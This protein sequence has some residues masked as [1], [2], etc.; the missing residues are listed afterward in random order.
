MHSPASRAGAAQ[1]LRGSAPA[2]DVTCVSMKSC[3]P[4]KSDAA[5]ERYLAHAALRAKSWPVPSEERVV[6][7]SFGQT[8]VRVSGPPDAA[9]V[10]LLPGIG[11]PGLTLAP[12]VAGLS[13]PRRT[14]VI[15]NIHDVGRSVE[16]K[17]VTGADDFT[18]WL[19]EVRRGLGLG[20]V[21]VLGLSYGGWIC[22]QYALRFPEAVRRVV[23]LAPA[24]TTAPIPWGFIWRAVLCAIPSRS[25]MRNFMG[26]VAPGLKAQR[27]D[28]L[29]SMVEDG[30]L[31]T[32][33]FAP[34]KMVPPLPLSD[35]QWARYQA[36]T[37][38]LAGDREV[39]FPPREAVE[40]LA[41]VAPHVQTA[42]LPAVGHDFF[43]VAAD[44]VNRRVLAFLE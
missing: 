9:A 7:T 5:R 19:D 2:R 16:T 27:P 6:P 32:R 39:I 36:R 12:V 22:A 20:V 8:F 24:G 40:K 21:D 25:F 38:F 29:E 26:W 44:E 18:T 35:A 34:R 14:F 41:R 15:D 10:L 11:S 33:S 37:L 17:P 3:A 1:P 31:A 28:L 23:L 30:H 13:G 42:L 4:F 43:L